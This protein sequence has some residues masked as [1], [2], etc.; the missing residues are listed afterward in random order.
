MRTSLLIAFLAFAQIVMGQQD[1]QYTQY[2]YNTQT[3]NPAYAGSRGV[4]NLTGLYR[5]QWVGINGAPE[6]SNF[7]L[8]TPV[9][10]RVGLG[11]SFYK[12]K[13]GI[14][15]EN[16]IAADVSYTLPLNDD[17]LF[18]SFGMKGGVNILDVDFS[19]LNPNDVND[20]SFSP[21]N[22][23][24]GQVSPI[25][26]IGLYL[27]NKDKWYLGISAPNLLNTDHYDDVTISTTKERL[28]Y[29]AIGGYVFDLNSSWKFKPAI[30]LKGV[31]GA[32]LAADFSANFLFNERFT[33]GAA[34][35]WDSAVSGL[36]GFQ[37]T[38][39][40]MLGYAYDYD[41]TDIGNYSNGSHEFFLRFEIGDGNNQGVVNP[42]FF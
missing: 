14:S 32:P 18:M 29:Y 10:N 19:Q 35:R 3:V 25:I 40:I 8:N 13:I 17:D 7:S 22:N 31:K 24:D 38:N 37:I 5:T 30:L 1:S 12:D 27:R 28:H 9:G 42:R 6:T 33:L 36:F 11:L 21:S 26:G 16:N 39:G 15:L 4:L 41:V 20:P 2:M 23:I 34:Y